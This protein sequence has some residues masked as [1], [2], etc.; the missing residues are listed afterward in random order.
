MDPFG[1]SVLSRSRA[2]ALLITGA[3]IG[4]LMITPGV[5]HVTDSFTH[6]KGHLDKR[7]V[8]TVQ[9]HDL[10]ALVDGGFNGGILAKAGPVTAVNYL[11][12]G[13]YGVRFSRPF[14]YTSGEAFALVTALNT[15]GVAC[16]W[17]YQGNRRRELRVRCYN[18]A[19]N[20]ADAQFTLAVFH[21]S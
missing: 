8:Q 20:P 19:G 7:Y 11:D 12:T 9:N 15:S 5:A 6:L 10:F 16:S 17:H 21:R 14:N 18:P 4:A 2:I 13:Y 1:A 3:I